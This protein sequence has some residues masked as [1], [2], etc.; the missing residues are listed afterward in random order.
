MLLP[1]VVL[2]A[3][4]VCAGIALGRLLDEAHQ[5]KGELDR[6]RALRPRL[7]EVGT[8]AQRLRVLLARLRDR[9]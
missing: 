3:G 1:A 6:A 2:L 9:Q 5:L 4:A 7:V 8:E